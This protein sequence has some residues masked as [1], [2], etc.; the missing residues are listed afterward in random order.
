MF[1][2]HVD[3]LFRVH[4]LLVAANRAAKNDRSSGLVCTVLYT[5]RSSTPR[6]K[7]LQS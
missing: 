6:A 3:P 4:F 1:A 5:F 2:P 7:Q